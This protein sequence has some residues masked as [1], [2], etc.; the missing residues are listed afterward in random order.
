MI[1]LS[2]IAGDVILFLVNQFSPSTPSLWKA[3]TS[4]SLTFALFLYFFRGDFQ[5][6]KTIQTD[7]TRDFFKDLKYI[8]LF[9]II[10]HFSKLLII[11]NP[12]RIDRNLFALIFSD[13]LSVFCTFISV[14]FYWF[15]YKWQYT[16]RHIGTKGY[17]KVINISFVVLIILFPVFDNP[18]IGLTGSRLPEILRDILQIITIIVLVTMLV[19]VLFISKKNEWIAILPKRKKLNLLLLTLITFLLMIAFDISHDSKDILY[20]TLYYFSPFSARLIYINVMILSVYFLRLLLTTLGSLPTAEIVE[21]QTQEIQS[22]T[23]LS[24]VLAVNRDIN[25]IIESVTEMALRASGGSSAWLEKYNGDEKPTLISL[26]FISETNVRELHDHFGL[27]RAFKNISEP[28]LIESVPEDDTFSSS[29]VDFSVYAKSLIAVPI[30]AGNLRYGTLVVLHSEEYGFNVERLKVLSSF[31]DNIAIAIENT[32]L[33][34]DSIEKEKYKKELLLARDMQMKLLPQKLPDIKNYD[35]SAYTKPA[36]EVGGDFYDICKLKNGKCCILIGDVSGKGI[37]AAFYMAQLKGIVL[38]LAK[39]SVSARDL[40]VKLND[41]LYGKMDRRVYITLSALVIDDEYGNI[42]LARAGHLPGLL[43][44]PGKCEMVK[45]SG[46]GLG[47]K[48]DAFF[49]KYIDEQK[50]TLN[51]KCALILIT[52]GVNEVRNENGVELGLNNLKLFLENKVCITSK[53]YIE[54][55]NEYVTEYMGSNLQ[56]D[57]ITIISLAF[58][59]KIQ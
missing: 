25:T 57:D 53:E 3:F 2:R 37:S 40:L 34:A 8:L 19:S 23:Y 27:E 22:L 15:F 56:H 1:I 47:L 42:S 35:I 58:N 26:K 31:N 45:P 52:D 17:L 4:I 48:D 38:A 36:E 49:S 30:Y 28:I 50:L 32:R 59:G 11:E 41:T 6:K 44:S 39:E 29:T 55:I 21:H 33:I 43:I 51:S 46:I 12:A 20:K 14:Y 18:V 5:S 7:F 13:L 10:L 24:K 9:I 16:H 54:S